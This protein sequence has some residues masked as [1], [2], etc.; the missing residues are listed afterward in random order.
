MTDTN[1]R[2]DITVVFDGA[3][4]GNPGPGGYAAI[5]VNQRTGSEKV[6]RGGSP[7]T[8]NNKMELTAA[9]QGLGALRPGAYVTMIG[10]AEYVT[11]GFTE[12]LPAWKAQGWRTADR[13]PVANRE[14]WEALD[15]AVQRHADGAVGVGSRARRPCFERA[16]G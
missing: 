5:L 7:A 8:T 1:P 3:C 2:R 12:W 14:L 9:I 4:L 10:D 11:K 15:T 16:G 6:V 13:K